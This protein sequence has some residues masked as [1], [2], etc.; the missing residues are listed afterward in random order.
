MHSATHLT[1]IKTYLHP[2]IT[3]TCS[4]CSVAAPRRPCPPHKWSPSWRLVSV[5]A[6]DLLAWVTTGT[7]LVWLMGGGSLTS[8]QCGESWK[9][10]NNLNNLQDCLCRDLRSPHAV[11]QG[12]PAAGAAALPTARGEVVFLVTLE[13]G[14]ETAGEHHHGEYSS[15]TLLCFLELELYFKLK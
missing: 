15:K 7:S 3:E 13:A 4:L 14:A 9:Y 1:S 5:R 12:R 11:V 2:I 10:F 8:A 6:G